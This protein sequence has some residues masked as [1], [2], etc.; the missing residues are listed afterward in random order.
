MAQTSSTPMRSGTLRRFEPGRGG[1]ARALSPI[2]WAALML[3]L[4]I[5]L[6]K[7]TPPAAASEADDTRSVIEQQLDAM[8]RDDWP[9]AYRFAAPSIQQIFPTPDLFANMVRRG[10]PMVWR[11][12]SVE[13]LGSGYLDDAPATGV[14]L[15][16]LRFV[17]QDGVSYIGRYYLRRVEGV[18]RIAGVE[19]EREPEASA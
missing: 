1:R 2:G 8:S 7:P 5:A 4:L 18:W 9:G 10:Y 6:A 16:R 12:S 13:F 19:I 11:P 14:Y 3:A 15:Q 17:D